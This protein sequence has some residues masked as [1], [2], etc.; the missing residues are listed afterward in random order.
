VLAVTPGGKTAVAALNKRTGATLWTSEV[1]GNEPAG[2]AT[3]AI[4]RVGDTKQYVTF[5]QNGLIAVNAATGRFLWRD[6]R[7]GK[8]SAANIPTS[9]AFRD[10]VFHSTNQGGGGAVRVRTA[11]GK[12]VAEPLYH[13]P[14]MMGANGGV[15]LV[16]GHLYGTNQRVMMCVELATGTEKWRDRSIGAAAVSLADGLLYLHGENGDV[17]LVEPSPVGYREKG[18]FTPPGQPDRKMARAW[19]HPVVANGRLYIRDL[20]TLWSYDVRGGK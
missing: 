8:G 4:A 20:G 6:D 15:V 2:Y 12:I 3:I 7:T 11:G 16:D 10:I 13:E 18:R 19:A 14:G 17:A 9:I 1:P 5:L